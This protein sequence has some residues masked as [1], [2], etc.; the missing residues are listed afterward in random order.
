[1]NGLTEEPNCLECIRVTD[2]HFNCQKNC[3]SK[4]GWFGFEKE[5]IWEAKKNEKSEKN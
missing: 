5:E 1:M 4:N 3:G 2:N